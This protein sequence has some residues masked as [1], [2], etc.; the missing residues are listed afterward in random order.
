MESV[1]YERPFVAVGTVAPS[2]TATG[3]LPSAVKALEDVVAGLFD[4]VALEEVVPEAS[5]VLEVQRLV[6][7]IL[8][9]SQ[10]AEEV[11][12][13][14]GTIRENVSACS[15][16]LAFGKFPQEQGTV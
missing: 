4:S 10:V 15:V 12:L 3:L 6:E 11:S 13:V 9:I 5:A 2:E 8:V 1:L 14:E 16:R 7:A